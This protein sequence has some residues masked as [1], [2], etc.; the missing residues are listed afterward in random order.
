MGIAA[1]FSRFNVRLANLQG[2][3]SARTAEGVWR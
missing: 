2:L 1:E 3:V